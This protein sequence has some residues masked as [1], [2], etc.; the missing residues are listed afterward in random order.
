[1]APVIVA[2]AGSVLDPNDPHWGLR[3][4][5]FGGRA[6][7][8]AMDSQSIVSDQMAMMLLGHI[9]RDVSI[10]RFPSISGIV[11]GRSWN[12]ATGTFSQ[13]TRQ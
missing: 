3:D 9:N 13:V 12:L 1:M 6:I 11:E 7:E 2:P 4:W 10:T 8:Y 5:K